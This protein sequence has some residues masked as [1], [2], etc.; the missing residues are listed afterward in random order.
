MWKNGSTA[1]SAAPGTITSASGTDSIARN[2]AMML[3]W[4]SMTP[5]G[6]PVVPL[7]YG[8]TATASGE[9]ATAG[10]VVLPPSSAVNGSLPGASPSAITGSS[11][12]TARIASTSGAVVIASFGEPTP[13][14][15]TSSSRVA[16]GLTIIATAPAAIAPWYAS[17]TSGRFGTMNATR[18]RG[19]MPRATRPLATLADRSSTWRNV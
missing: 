8:I 10:G 1:I 17:A 15:L 4:V 7:E 18:S 3:R 12:A 13:K 14:Y 5:L 11:G 16:S 6:N 19:A 2:C 9:I